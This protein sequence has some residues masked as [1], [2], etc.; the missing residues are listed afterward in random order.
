MGL[1]VAEPVHEDLLAR[2]RVLPDSR[3]YTIDV[4]GSDAQAPV[5]ATEADRAAAAWNRGA[6][7]PEG[8]VRARDLPT[9]RV[10]LEAEV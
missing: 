2:D 9:S 1:P 10:Q 4:A 3:R 7:T 8:G 5:V 6:S